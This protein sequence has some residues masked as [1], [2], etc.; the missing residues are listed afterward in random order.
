MYNLFA[1]TIVPEV[2]PALRYY[3]LG[4]ILWSPLGGGLHGGVLKKIQ[5]GRHLT[6]QMQQT[7]ERYRPQLEAY[8]K[9]CADL[10]EQPP[11]VALAWLLHNPA[12]TVTIVGPRTTE[13]LATSGRAFDVTLPEDAL[14]KL[15]EIW[16]GPGG[17]APEA[18]CW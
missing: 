5:G 13:Q 6:P 15:D 10:G 9:L 16:P 11:D 18:Y 1:R 4:L 8:E 2:I 3:G 12:V 17:E 7:I 14:D